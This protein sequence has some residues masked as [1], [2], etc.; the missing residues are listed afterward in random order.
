MNS[1][2]SDEVV[3]MET[4]S[5]EDIPS[6]GPP[7]PSL[8]LNPA[9]SPLGREAVRGNDFSNSVFVNNSSPNEDNACTAHD[10]VLPPGHRETTRNH[11][12]KVTLSMPSPESLPELNILSDRGMLGSG[13]NNPIPGNE[14]ARVRRAPSI[15]QSDAG[16]GR[17]T[18]ASRSPV[19]PIIEPD[20][21]TLLKTMTKHYS[22]FLNSVAQLND[23]HNQRVLASSAD[24]GARQEILRLKS[25][26]T[27]L[28]STVRV[29]TE[30][31]T[32]VRQDLTDSNARE[33]QL[34][35]SFNE[36][37]DVLPKVL[38]G[39]DFLPGKQTL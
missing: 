25:E 19:Q 27:E 38:G 36:I 35:S 6:G 34:Q 24:A 12:E 22:Q 39:T 23:A 32:R 11:G 20:Y 3:G 2:S 13:S 17:P 5:S 14:N 16:H 18:P 21:G 7:S 10:D 29:L 4:E 37:K 8:N 26:N 1:S 30:E 28:S 31:L 33:S 15:P 9:Q